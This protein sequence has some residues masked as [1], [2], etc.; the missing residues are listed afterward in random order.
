METGELT[1]IAVNDGI[2]QFNENYHAPYVPGTNQGGFTGGKICVLKTNYIAAVVGK[3]L[4]IY[5]LET[6]EEKILIDNIGDEYYFGNPIGSIDGTKVIVTRAPFHPD[7][8]Q[9]NT[10]PNRDKKEAWIEEFGGMPTTYLQIDIESGNV[11]E[12]HKE[13][14]GGSHHVQP[15]PSEPHIWL[16]DRDFPPKFWAGGD[17][18]QSTRA[19]LLNTKNNNLIEIE[20]EDD[21]GFQVHS[22]W[23]K[24]GDKIYYHG[25]SKNGGQYIGVADLQGDIIWEH[26]ILG[27]NYGHVSTHTGKEAIITDGLITPDMITAIH[28]NKT[29]YTGVP[30]IELLAQHNTQWDG[31]VGQYPH[32]HCHMSPDGKW[33]SYNKAE[34]GRTDVCLVRIK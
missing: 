33:L 11:K 13:E 9:G 21:Y 34:N 14:V 20:P 22:T 18:F 7:Y 30:Q 10:R 25:P 1:V 15:C 31:M 32:P 4:R 23:S 28:Y 3:S 19:W 29:N 17:N 12:V 16:I 8:A 2:G 27:D 26:H 5:D 6:Y 24:N